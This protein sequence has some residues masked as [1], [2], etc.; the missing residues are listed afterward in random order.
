MRPG[1]DEESTLSETKPIDAVVTAIVEGSA[2]PHVRSAAAR[3]ALP[4]PRTTLV[5]LQIVLREDADEGTRLAARSNLDALDSDSIAEVLAD[6]TCDPTVLSFFAPRAAREEKL[7]E[8][9]AFHPDV[10][11]TALMVLASKGGAAVV[12]LVLTNQERLLEQPMLLELLTLNPA[13]RADQRGRILELLDRAA[14]LAEARRA[15]DA[16]GAAAADPEELEL[17]AQLLEVDV[18]DL[19]SSSEILGAEE[20]E[21]S[22]DPQIRST[23][24]R[25]LTLN[26]AQKA[27]MA[28]KGGRE[29]RQI[30]VRDTNRVVALGV[31]K[32]P[33][34]QETEIER[35][36]RMRN[37][38]DVVLQ[39]LG[40]TRAWTKS[41]A[42]IMALIT[43]PRTPQTV[44]ANFIPRLTNRDLKNLAK[45]REVPELIRR[46]ARRTF[47][48]RTQ[49][50]KL[51][52][53]RH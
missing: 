10:P 7:A 30:L 21:M 40:T 38:T 12:E 46:M 50:D 32:N 18:G 23:F 28:M 13:L 15:E 42:V 47:D 49:K 44:S 5:R 8:K 26:T 35:I 22:E 52:F 9:L 4:L 2:P 16:D 14:R 41:Y 37:V 53:G 24:A 45:S 11:K 19:L 48:V 31:L 36:A 20:L 39:A 25:I 33:R 43:N 51:R 27:I 3:G 29:E 17:A 1:R 34:I 6:A